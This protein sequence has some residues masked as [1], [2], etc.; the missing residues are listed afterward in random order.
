VE[1]AGPPEDEA[2]DDET[3]LEVALAA[4]DSLTQA[5]EI[6]SDSPSGGPELAAVA[7]DIR[8]AADAIAEAAG[9]EADDEAAEAEAEGEGE[10]DSTA[11]ATLLSARSSS[12]SFRASRS[13]SS[14]GA[15]RVRCA[16]S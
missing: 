2:E 11:M 8:Q 9:V 14:R 10:S 15:S 13:S 4:L 5:V 7:L 1:G 6:L 3:P 12:S 16:T